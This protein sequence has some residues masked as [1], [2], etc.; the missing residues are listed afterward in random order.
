MKKRRGNV[1]GKG[2]HVFISESPEHGPNRTELLIYKAFLL[3]YLFYIISVALLFE[4]EKQTAALQ[5]P[6]V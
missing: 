4:P 2:A 6:L 3:Y 5:E 1:A